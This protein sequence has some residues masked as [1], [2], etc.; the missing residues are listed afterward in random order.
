MSQCNGCIAKYQDRNYLSSFTGCFTP[1]SYIDLTLHNGT[2]VYV[3]DDAS[4]FC[5]GVS[6]CKIDYDVYL[7]A[8]TGCF[9]KLSGYFSD[10][11]TSTSIVVS[12]GS[13]QSGMLCLDYDDTWQGECNNVWHPN[14]VVVCGEL[15]GQTGWQQIYE[16][17]FRCTDCHPEKG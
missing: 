7:C 16:A 13:G 3:G 12:Q 4:G 10:G 15:F 9:T 5:S 2:C 8:E 14:Q 17:D 1:S 11:S 6:G